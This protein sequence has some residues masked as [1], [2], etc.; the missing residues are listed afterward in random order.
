MQSPVPVRLRLIL[1]A[2]LAALLLTGAAFAQRTLVI[3]QAGDINTI[4]NQQSV[5]AAK[6]AILQIY[7]WQWIRFGSD[8]LPDG[9]RTSNRDLIP[10]IIESW[11]TVQHADG[12][13]TH[14]F[15][16]R[17]GAVHHS[18]NPIIAEDFVYTLARRA[19]LGRD[20]V[21][22]FFG[23]MY[24]YSDFDTKVRVID[25]LTFEV[26]V[27]RVM[28]LFWDIWAQR[29]YYDSVLM[30][31]NATA[32][33]PW[34]QKF[35]QRGDAGAGPYTVTRW[36]TGVEMV[37]DRF[38]NYW[39]PQP[40]F[41]QLVFRTI[42]DLS[43]R[44]LL[45]RTGAVDVA[46]DLPLQ[47][48]EQL[49]NDRNI[50]VI[51]TPSIQQLFIGFNANIAPYDN[52]DLRLA[53]SYAFPYDTVVDQAY[54]GQAIHSYGPTPN[55]LEGALTERAF[56]ENME[57]AREHL[58]RSGLGNNL[59][60]TLKYSTA[61]PQHE[62]IGIL[63]RENLR[64]LGIDLELQRLPVGEFETGIRTTS[65]DFFVRE[66]LA[67]V[68]TPEYINLLNFDSESSANQ[69]GYKNAEAD[70]LI[71]AAL[72]ENDPAVRLGISKLV[73]EKILED[74]P[75]IFIAH[76]NHMIAFRSDLSGYVTQ[77]T[78]LHHFWEMAR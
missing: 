24:G 3:A 12:T 4:D 18:G 61:L 63:F 56:P 57:L 78:Q 77:N 21:H 40:Y 22:R 10:G 46:L 50:T 15:H 66:S 16:I 65:L 32:D 62:T 49:R 76:P 7:D 1:I 72:I 42:P 51:S 33:D 71:R 11:E 38:E 39:G 20:Y 17:P 69:V 28:P 60:L 19:S 35:A 68:T 73:Q 47:E 5:G 25:P 36:E 55:L 43:S 64:A 14:R 53:L 37:L 67:W 6:N 27:E 30:E 34:A 54:L 52:K 2:L 26:D 44:V 8:T 31:Q 58:Q 45:L 59:K 75:W 29:T 13:A 23:G 48:L 70:V 41:D 9:S 74:V